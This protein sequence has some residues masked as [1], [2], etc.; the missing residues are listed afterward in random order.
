MMKYK[1]VILLE[2]FM[3]AHKLL[4]PGNTEDRSSLFFII[5]FGYSHDPSNTSCDPWPP[6]QL[7]A[8]RLPYRRVCICVAHDK[9]WRRFSGTR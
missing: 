1:E 7:G 2:S 9:H 5:P 4:Q 3:Q 6:G 8:D